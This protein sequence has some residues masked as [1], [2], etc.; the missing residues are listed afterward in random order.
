[1]SCCDLTLSLLYAAMNR[2]NRFTA[3]KRCTSYGNSVCPSVCPSVTRP[4][5][6]KTTA[7]S[8]VQFALLDSKMCSFIETKTIP[9]GRP[10]PPEIL[11]PSDLPPPEGSE[12]WHILPCSASTVRDRKRRSITL[13]KNS[14]WASQRAINQGSMLPLTSSKWR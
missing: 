3:R 6:V 13:N 5:C 7:R 1:M 4:Y 8:T 2:H 12:C 14:T 9:Q 10:L 11:A